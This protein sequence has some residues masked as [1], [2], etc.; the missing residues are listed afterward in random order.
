VRSGDPDHACF[1]EARVG[2]TWIPPRCFV[3]R[4]NVGRFIGP[5]Q[6]VDKVDEVSRLFC[7]M[8]D[9][10]ERSVQL[11]QEAVRSDHGGECSPIVVEGRVCLAVPVRLHK[12][13][14]LSLEF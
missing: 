1:F 14:P 12:L 8:C 4:W 9:A 10:A 6:G 2:R 11:C 3:P 7:C 5:G 13:S